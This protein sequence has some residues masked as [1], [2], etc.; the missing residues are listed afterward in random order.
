MTST[1]PLAVFDWLYHRKTTHSRTILQMDILF[2][3]QFI[4][5]S[6]P[7]ILAQY[8]IHYGNSFMGSYKEHLSYFHLHL[9][10]HVYYHDDNTQN[11]VLTKKPSKHLWWLIQYGWVF[12][13]C[14][15][16]RQIRNLLHIMLFCSILASNF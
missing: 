10:L 1:C 7:W 2:V 8:L 4:L 16:T 11:A 5:R 6:K 14:K 13:K 15:L 9:D 3:H 12:C